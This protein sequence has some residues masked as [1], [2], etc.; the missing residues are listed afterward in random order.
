METGPELSI[1]LRAFVATLLGLAIGWQREEAGSAAGDRTFALV[2]LGTA[3]MTGFAL[4]A[5][6]QNADRL[7]AGA[8][9]GI[10]FLGA[11]ILMLSRDRE[12]FSTAASV[13]AISA[14]GILVGANLYLAAFLLGALVWFILRWWERLPIARKVRSPERDAEPTDEARLR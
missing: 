5:F 1:V 3:A 12:A 11:G 4:Y 10:G 13:W 7:I 9:T 2:A 8:I 14:L 6:P